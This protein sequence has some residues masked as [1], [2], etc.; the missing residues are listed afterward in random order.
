MRVKWCHDIIAEW[1]TL[2]FFHV[3]SGR[4]SYHNTLNYGH[5]TG[6]VTQMTENVSASTKCMDL[7][8]AGTKILSHEEFRMSYLYT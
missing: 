6:N 3:L 7:F 5:I 8:D 4:Y 2:T 1:V